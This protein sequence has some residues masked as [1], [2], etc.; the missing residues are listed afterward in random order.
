MPSR[1][2]QHRCLPPWVAGVAW[3]LGAGLLSP[4]MAAISVVGQAFA[5]SGHAFTFAAGACGP[6][7]FVEWRDAEGTLAARESTTRGTTS[8]EGTT[9][10]STKPD[11]QDWVHYRL[12]RPNVG[13]SIEGRKRGRA[14]TL[15]IE[16]DGQRQV[17]RMTLS[18]GVIAG[19]LLIPRLQSAL[20]AL[21]EGQS[22]E[23][24]YL[25]ADQ[26][27]VLRLRV[28]REPQLGR[29]YSAEAKFEQGH[30]RLRM[31]AASPWMRPFVPQTWLTFD[32]R[33]EL[34][35]ME[36]RLLPLQGSVRRPLPLTGVL[37][38]SSLNSES[39]LAASIG[40]SLA[41]SLMAMQSSCNRADL[42]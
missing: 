33:G 10:E 29:A 22:L 34:T 21:R 26:A 31:E 36:G 19:P 13:Q 12:E 38:V 4:S 2:G 39:A 15:T 27:A 30:V 24:D 25:I 37:N 1:R 17:K 7:L 16:R 32:A 40:S 18:D 35:Q 41:S 8:P 42:T 20:P 6:Q 5:E 9:P 28:E 23:L 3:A 11:A 14:L